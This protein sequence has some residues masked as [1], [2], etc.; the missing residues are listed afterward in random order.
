MC[1]ILWDGVIDTV[2]IENTVLGPHI[3]MME[4]LPRD[5]AVFDKIADGL[6]ETERTPARVTLCLPRDSVMQQTLRYPAMVS[7]DIGNMIE[8]EASRHV[9]LPEEDR[10]LAYS[11]TLS[12]DEQQLIVDLQAARQS[13][14]RNLISGFSAVGVPVDE[15]VSFTSLIAPAMADAPTLLVVSGENYVELC[16][17]GDGIQQ[18]NQLIS[19]LAPGFSDERIITAVRQMAAQ[20]K[21]WLGD[22]GI[23]RVLLAGPAE[24]SESF[25]EDLGTAF[26]LHTRRLDIPADLEPACAEAEQ[27]PLLE[28]IL[29]ASTDISLTGNLIEARK[30]RVPLSKRTVIITALCAL[31]AV[32]LIAA[33][34]LKTYAPV[35]QRKEI[36]EEIARMKKKTAPVQEMKEQNRALREELTRLDEMC[37]TRVSSM[38]I[39][40]VLTETFPEDSYM[41]YIIYRRAHSLRIKGYSKDPNK[42]PE[43]VLAMPFVKGIDKSDI[44]KKKDEYH[45]IDLYLALRSPDEEE[46]DS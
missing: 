29:A 15:A 25:G 8:F 7:S 16:L 5:E 36:A 10:S 41:R 2:F 24:I 11:N 44:D 3:R 27:E 33:L 31:L 37:K 22:E 28:A 30:R 21:E 1:I 4:R 39:L 20:N 14:I 42:L 13:E 17:Y 18:D 38:E 34:A 32:E 23:G 19:R 45:E 12:A 35:K 6:R 43:L 9:P 26:G 40:R 46:D